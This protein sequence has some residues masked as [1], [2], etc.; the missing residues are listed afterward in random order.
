MGHQGSGKTTLVETIISNVLGQPAGAIERKNT[1]SDFT[2]EEKNRLSSCS[3]TVASLDYNGYH[4]NLLDA[5]GNDDFVAD[6]IGVLDMVKAAVLVLDA[7]K[8]IEVGTV[9]HYNML[10]RKGIPT[11]IFVQ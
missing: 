8:K 11:F 5:P 1:V 10:K 4:L 9:K 7:G 3:L 6:I 2:T